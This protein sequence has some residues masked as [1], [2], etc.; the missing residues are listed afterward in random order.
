MKNIIEQITNQ[1]QD[2]DATQIAEVLWLSQFLPKGRFGTAKQNETTFKTN[3]HTPI[4]FA[5]NL[6]KDVTHTIT[7]S[8]PKLQTD[9]VATIE[10]TAHSSSS[11]SV[12]IPNRDYLPPIGRQFKDLLVKQYKQSQELLD[13][14]KSAEYVASTGLFYPIFAQE[15]L[16]GSY[17][18]LHI[19]A[20][21]SSSMF[22]W[23]E[24]IEHFVNSLKFSREFGRVRYFEMDSS[25]DSLEIY[26]RQKRSKISSTSAI[27]KQKRTLTLLFSDIV[28]QRWKSGQMLGLLEGW[29]HYSL[30]AIVSM[31]PRYMWQRT[32][33]RR[34][35]SRFMYAKRFAPTNHDLRAEH[36]FIEQSFT[37]PNLKIPIIP[38]N[39]RAFGYLSQI[40]LGSRG[41]LIDTK[42]FENL[43]QILDTPKPSK[44]IDATTKV[45]RFLNSAS[46]SSR[47]LAIYCSILPL[48]K[49]II[50]E[51][52]KVKDLGRGMEAFAEF[53][54][55]GLLDRDAVVEIGEYEFYEGVRAE[56]WEYISMDVAGEIYEIVADVTRATLGVSHSMYDLLYTQKATK[57]PRL[58]PKELAL[59]KLLRE[60][61]GVKGRYYRRDIERL[62]SQIETV[63][64]DDN[65]FQMGSNEYNDEKP[66]HKVTFDYDFEIAKYPVT[67]EEYDLYCKYEEVKKPSDEGWGRGRRPAI[68]VSWHDAVAYCEWLSEK[69]GKEYRLPT[70]AEWEYACRAGST[71]RWSFGDDE[72]ELEKYAWYKKNSDGKTHLVGL[73]MSN[74]WGIHDMHGNV[75]EWCKNE[76]VDS[77]KKTPRDGTAH[78]K[79]N[80]ERKVLRGGSWSG[81]SGGTCSAY[82][83]GDLPALR[84]GFRGFRLLRTLP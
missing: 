45:R 27:F 66:I 77:Y 40:L 80:R 46:A 79:G 48:H 34:G 62:T 38:Y 36:R 41:A 32:A 55:G 29:S 76:W 12:D 20:D 43:E 70:E 7:I 11:Y 10:P 54:F 2:A 1:N 61:L 6:P 82:R 25:A 16:Y 60:I 73:T 67:F 33:L 58:N 56:L 21:S 17:F 49:A 53:Y 75:W 14:T 84:Y 63:Y 52:I 28:G 69:S 24:Y 59:A 68:N 42:V 31:L 23:R 22:L 35:E 26:D 15:K 72:S 71:T 5:P 39:E 83:Y 13:E 78:Y 81:G 3:T 65:S 37:K 44:E 74:D 4:H 47:E 64:L 50:E 57:T 51:I 19:V 30:V 9:E 8:S 18:D